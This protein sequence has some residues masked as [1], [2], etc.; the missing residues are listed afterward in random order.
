MLTGHDERSTL[1]QNMERKRRTTKTPRV[2]GALA[3]RLPRACLSGPL[4]V[5]RLRR[6]QSSDG[7]RSRWLQASAALRHRP[8]PPPCSGRGK[9]RGR[10]GAAVVREGSTCY[11]TLRVCSKC[12]RIRSA[13]SP[14]LVPAAGP[15]NRRRCPTDG[16]G[17]GPR[18]RPRLPP[19]RVTQRGV[20]G[21]CVC[22][23]ACAWCG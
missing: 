18:M 23:R 17:T 20:R 19:A 22:V 11:T 15:E 5:R 4:P 16:R 21:V 12:F 6:G 8:L 13:P 1:L 2:L 3:A 10:G 7:S 9:V 14:Q